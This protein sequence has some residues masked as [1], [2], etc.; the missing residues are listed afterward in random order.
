MTA[1]VDSALPEFYTYLVGIAGGSAA[2]KTTFTRSLIAAL[3]ECARTL[4]VEVVGMDRYFYRG[5]AGGPT[6]FVPS[7]GQTLPDNNHPDSAD[8]AR[9]LED[10]DALCTDPDGPDVLIVEGLMALFLPELRDRMHLRLFLELDAD[11]RALRRLLRDMKG[12]R[13]SQDPEFI[14]AYYRECARVGHLRYV[15]PSRSHADLILRGDSDF[16]RTAAIVAS[17]IVAQYSTTASRQEVSGAALSR[18]ADPTA[19]AP[20]HGATSEQREDDTLLRPAE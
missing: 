7:L 18:S 5:A 3:Q 11:E 8:N 6:V 19:S 1:Q 16:S 20:L 13:G 12:G 17:I 4:R 9:L 14:A 2:G 15:E 10:L